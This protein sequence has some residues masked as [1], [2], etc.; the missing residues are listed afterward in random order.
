MHPIHGDIINA[1][2]AGPAAAGEKHARLIRGR[3][4]CLFYVFLFF[5]L[6]SISLF[7][8]HTHTHT[9]HH[10]LCERVLYAGNVW[11]CLSALSADYYYA[12]L[13]RTIYTEIAQQVPQALAGIIGNRL[14]FRC[15]MLMRPFFFREKFYCMTSFNIEIVGSNVDKCFIGKDDKRTDKEK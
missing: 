9:E 15:L 6:P 8:A 2:A 1:A 7:P 13:R 10:V 14:V 11:S 4:M 12:F 5:H 3:T